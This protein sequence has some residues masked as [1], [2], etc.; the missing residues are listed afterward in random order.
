M[1]QIAATKFCIRFKN[2]AIETF[3]MLEVH[4]MKYV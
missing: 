4:T 2:T 1:E 3:G